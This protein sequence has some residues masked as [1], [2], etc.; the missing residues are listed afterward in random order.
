MSASYFYDAA[1]VGAGPAGVAAAVAAAKG[2]L[3]VVLIDAAARLGGTVTAGLHRVLCGLYAGAPENPC[4]TLNAGVQRDLVARMVARDP[5]AVV[6]RQLGQ[7][8]VLEFPPTAWEAA[9]AELCTEAQVTV[10]LGV[11]VTEVRRAGRRILALYLKGPEPAWVAARAVIDCTGEGSILQ[12]TGADVLL[13]EIRVPRMLGGMAV[14]LGALQGDLEALRLEI[15]YALAKAVEAGRLPATA[16]F[17]LFHPGPG[18]AEGVCK[19]ALHPDDFSPERAAAFVERVLQILVKEIPALAAAR[20]IEQS[21]R[22]LPRDGHHL[23]GRYILSESDI[24]TPRHHGLDAVRGWW[25]IEQ[26]DLADGPVYAYPPPGEAYEIPD[27][28]L[29]SAILDNLYA[30]GNCLSATPVA[31][32]SVRA[33]GICLA[34]GDAAG[35]LAA[36]LGA[37]RV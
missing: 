13:P 21:P 30:A 34:T 31:A 19:L 17:T 27:E 18:E 32:A 12:M 7:V 26:W 22:A 37:R 4:D 29:Q 28:A 5:A 35:R 2:G 16:R 20:V 6:V 15:P 24:L 1:V 9:L 23:R 8:W 33:A 14:R 25:P 10:R 3:R 36:R 11:P